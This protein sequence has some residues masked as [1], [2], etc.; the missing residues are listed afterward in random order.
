MERGPFESATKNMNP[1]ERAAWFHKSALHGGRPPKHPQM[2]EHELRR[3]RWDEVR[4]V[5][6][7]GKT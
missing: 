2:P 4:R 3:E 6:I 1:E 5:L 7:R